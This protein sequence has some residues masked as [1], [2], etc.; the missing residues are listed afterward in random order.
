[1]PL[2]VWI[3]S[4]VGKYQTRMVL[5]SDPEARNLPS[6]E[7]ARDSTIRVCPL[8][9]AHR[10]HVVVSQTSTSP[11]RAV[12][13]A[14]PSR[15]NATSL[16]KGRIGRLPFPCVARNRPCSTSQNR[17][18]PSCPA[19]EIASTF[20]PGVYLRQ[21]IMSLVDRISSLLPPSTSRTRTAQR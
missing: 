14:A 4:P 19:A 13:V 16:L 11:P 8:S 9:V 7:N 1:N 10:P 17:I 15:E 12:A 21:K 6:G 20:P 5:S 2:K 3:G 18:R